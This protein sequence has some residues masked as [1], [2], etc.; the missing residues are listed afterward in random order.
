MPEQTEDDED[1]IDGSKGL[2][3]SLRDCMNS[4]GK[5]GVEKRDG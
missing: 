4:S 1:C 3:E 2:I 5:S